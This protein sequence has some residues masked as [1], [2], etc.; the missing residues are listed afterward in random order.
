L[1]TQS[2]TVIIATYN[3]ENLLTRLIFN[4]KQQIS[5]SIHNSEIIAVDGGSTDQTEQICGRLGVRFIENTRGD[6]VSGKYV[7]LQAA[8]N[9]LVVF[10]D[11]DELFEQRDSLSRKAA[12]LFEDPKVVAVSSTGYSDLIGNSVQRYISEFG[13]PFTGFFYRTSQAAS[14]REVSLTRYLKSVHLHT[15]DALLFEHAPG[16]R[17]VLWE[18]LSM[19]TMVSKSRAEKALGKLALFPEAWPHLFSY[20]QHHSE[21]WK[22]GY[23]RGDPIVHLTTSDWFSYFQKLRWRVINQRNNNPQ[24]AVSSGISG[25]LAIEF[26]KKKALVLTSAKICYLL[27]VLLLFPVLF[28]SG[29]MVL[30]RKSLGFFGHFVAAWAIVYYGVMSQLLALIGVE[31]LQKRY[32]S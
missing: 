24:L 30:S 23:L 13:D 8:R 18:L 25:R 26:G 15:H 11:Q 4:L 1:G 32:S 9:D 5:F 16:G 6:A 27:Y 17:W 10:I 22:V 3:A 7:G 12:I 19:G 29:Q 2:W 20:L 21:T 31:Q 28:H 14:R